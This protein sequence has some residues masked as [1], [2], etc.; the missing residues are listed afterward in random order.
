VNELG[1]FRNSAELVLVG[2]AV[3]EKAAWVRA[4]VE[5]ALTDRP[6][7][8]EWSLART[9]HEDADTDRGGFAC[10]RRIG[11]HYPC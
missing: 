7:S 3:E 2:L 8:V 11:R 5:A 9:D 10:R 6:A 4:Q 1:G